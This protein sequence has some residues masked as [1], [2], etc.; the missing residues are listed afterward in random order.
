MSLKKQY[1]ET[2]PICKVTFKLTKKASNSAKKANLAGTFNDWN[3]SDLPMKQLKNGD[4]TV[5]V[6]LDKG[7]EYQFKYVIDGKIWIN[8]DK[9][10]SY[11]P[12]EFH[13]DNSVVAV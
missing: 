5:S 13:S 6:N 3:I 7:N 2:K 12:N 8:D 9:A 4:F 1:S 10:D 11:T